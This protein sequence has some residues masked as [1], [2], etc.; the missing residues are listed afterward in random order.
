MPA[1]AGRRVA[2]YC[3][4]ISRHMVIV[5]MPERFV[6]WNMIRREIN[7]ALRRTYGTG[8]LHVH[9]VEAL[10]G[11]PGGDE[12][13]GHVLRLC[14]RGFAGDRDVLTGFALHAWNDHTDTFELVRPATKP[15]DDAGRGA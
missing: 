14:E 8:S 2:L 1:P 10:A 13:D 3:T 6:P 4:V 11:L 12:D 7:A 5:R 9:D 15:A